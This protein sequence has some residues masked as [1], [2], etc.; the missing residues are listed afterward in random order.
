MLGCAANARHLREE[1]ASDRNRLAGAHWRRFHA[2]QCRFDHDQG[3]LQ[4]DVRTSLATMLDPARMSD[5]LLRKYSSAASWDGTDTFDL[6]LAPV[7]RTF[8]GETSRAYQS[9]MVRTDARH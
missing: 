1:K 2:E 8:V 5:R 9:P 4:D 7:R 3:T 6:P